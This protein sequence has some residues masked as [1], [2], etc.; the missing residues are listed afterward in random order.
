MISASSV[1]IGILVYSSQVDIIM[2]DFKAMRFFSSMFFFHFFP[3]YINR[4]NGSSSHDH[5]SSNFAHFV[6]NVLECGIVKPERY[7]PLYVIDSIMP[8]IPSKLSIKITSKILARDCSMTQNAL[9]SNE[10]SSVYEE[11]SL[12]AAVDRFNDAVTQIIDSTTP[13]HCENEHEFR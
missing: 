12:D 1:L 2:P 5:V 10:W 3:Q 11:I 8:F 13:F 9:H 6:I 4:D 7:R